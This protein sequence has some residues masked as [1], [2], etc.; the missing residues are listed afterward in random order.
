MCLCSTT[1]HPTLHHAPHRHLIDDEDVDDDPIS[2][3]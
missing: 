3:E 1:L 2:L